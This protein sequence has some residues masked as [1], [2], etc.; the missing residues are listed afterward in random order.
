M[1]FSRIYDIGASG[2]QAQTHRLNAIASNLANANRAAATENQAYRA[3]DPIFSAETH[4][5]GGSSVVMEGMVTRQDAIEKRYEPNNP[6]ANKDGHVFY[7]NVNPV[8]EMANMMSASRNFQTSVEVLK[9]VN[10]MQQ[11][12]LQLGRNGR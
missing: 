2:M 7:S 1:S 11:S 3:I 9:R 12:V 6:L 4:S 10:S 5:H 8:E